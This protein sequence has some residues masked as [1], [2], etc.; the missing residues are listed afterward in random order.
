MKIAAIFTDYDGTLAPSD[1]RREDSVIPGPLL[2]VLSEISSRIPVAIV[3]SKDLDFVRPRTP[4]AWAWSTV[5]GLEVR[6]RDGSGRQAHVT[7]DLQGVLESGRK[8]LPA[9]VVV[10]EK[11]GTDG[12]L[13]GV[14]LDWTSIPGSPPAELKVAK[15]AFRGEGFQIGSYEGVK[16]MDIYAAPTDKG[17]AVRELVHLLGVEGPV[18][19]LGD[20][21]ADN[22]AFKEC[23]VSICIEHS[24]PTGGLNCGYSVQYLELPTLLERLLADRFEF[25]GAE[26]KAT[27]G[28]RN[29]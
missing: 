8:T 22:D 19:Y 12:A 1:V 6:L 27:K 16:Y 5:L 3:T 21:E 25:D 14:S 10:E 28:A 15:T 20:T 24:Q 11:R 17:S 2:S 13:L 29:E 7:M 23:G 18:M 9:E 26:A 4:F